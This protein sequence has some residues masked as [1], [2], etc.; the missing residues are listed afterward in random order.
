MTPHARRA[1]VG[2]IVRC[3]CGGHTTMCE[4]RKYTE[5][6]ALATGRE[7]AAPVGARAAAAAASRAC[8]RAAATE[9]R[10]AHAATALA[11]KA[12]AALDSLQH[13]MAVHD[14][15]EEACC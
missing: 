12:D 15:H 6:P 10:T 11:Q 14:T 7:G 8:R 5:V 1:V 4:N 3:D 9:Q 13:G 2:G